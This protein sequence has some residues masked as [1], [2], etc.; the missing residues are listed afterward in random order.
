MPLC[1]PA[2][3]ALPPVAEQDLRD[4]VGALRPD[5]VQFFLPFPTPSPRQPTPSPIPPSFP[6]YIGTQVIWFVNKNLELT[7]AQVAKRK[8]PEPPKWEQLSRHD[9]LTLETAARSPT[10]AS[11]TIAM[12]PPP[13]SPAP[14]APLLSRSLATPSHVVFAEGAGCAIHGD[15]FEVDLYTRL[16]HPIYWLEPPRRVLRYNPAAITRA[17]ARL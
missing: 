8:T 1:R 4:V 14:A 10:P 6:S 2:T 12:P 17:R 7:P 13:T 5:E 16:A 9:C 3:P 11:R 15:L